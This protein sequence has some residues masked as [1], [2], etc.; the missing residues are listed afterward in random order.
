M[1]LLLYYCIL[2]HYYIVV[3]MDQVH[4]PMQVKALQQIHRSFNTEV[5]ESKLGHTN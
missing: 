1:A 2:M 5:M 4:I 3:P